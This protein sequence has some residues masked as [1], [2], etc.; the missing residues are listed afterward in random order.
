VNV[1]EQVNGCHNWIP[2]R[3]RIAAESRSVL[4]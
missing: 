1:P 2:S 3:H 4:N